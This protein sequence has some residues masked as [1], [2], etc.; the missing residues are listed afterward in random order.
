M[1]RGDLDLA[2]DIPWLVTQLP[3]PAQTAGR[4]RSDQITIQEVADH[5]PL[6]RGQLRRILDRARR[7]LRRMLDD[8]K[9]QAFVGGQ[10]GYEKTFSLQVLRK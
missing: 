4:L 8:L 6:T 3:E 7:R 2:M 5:V 9:L 1:R 10:G